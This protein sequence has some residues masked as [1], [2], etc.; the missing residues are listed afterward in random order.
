[1]SIDQSRVSLPIDWRA[2][3]NPL[4]ACALVALGEVQSALV[5][6]LH[7]QPQYHWRAIVFPQ[8]VL[9]EGQY[10]DLPWVDGC[11]YLGADA[12]APNLLIPTQ[13]QPCFS[14]E[15]VEQALRKQAMVPHG[16]L[17]VLPEQEMILDLRGTADFTTAALLERIDES[18]NAHP[19]EMGGQ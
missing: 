14:I 5:R 8:L 13:L 16:R 9:L 1:M 7:L 17:A 4:V 10:A 3:R 2:R 12:A 19:L 18:I 15:L 6:R 11:V